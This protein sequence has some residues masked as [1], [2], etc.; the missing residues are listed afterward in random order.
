MV[1]KYWRMY[2]KLVTTKGRQW[3]QMKAKLPEKHFA[4]AGLIATA[5]LSS[6]YFL[7]D[8]VVS[9]YSNLL[10]QPPPENSN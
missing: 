3:E 2:C 5:P 1:V 6:N 8:P 9:K 7:V 4:K 10:V